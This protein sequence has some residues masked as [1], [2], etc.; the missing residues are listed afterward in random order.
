LS[1]PDTGLTKW[2]YDLAGNLKA[3]ET[4]RLRAQSKKVRYVH[5]YNRLVQVDYPDSPD[6]F[7][8]YGMPHEFGLAHGNVAGRVKFE[9]SEAGTRHL[10]YDELGNTV[11]IA[12]EFG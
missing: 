5:E 12:M 2:S 9:Q 11:R 7:Y 4:A 1:S 3:K 10:G 6:R 8:H